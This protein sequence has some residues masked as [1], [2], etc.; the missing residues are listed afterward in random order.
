MIESIINHVKNN[1]YAVN[2]INKN[3]SKI[4]KKK[5]QSE[6]NVEP[7]I[8]VLQHKVWDKFCKKNHAYIH[9]HYNYFIERFQFVQDI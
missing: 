3:K 5:K 1:S 6:R 8:L 4:N 9:I 7:T 2:N